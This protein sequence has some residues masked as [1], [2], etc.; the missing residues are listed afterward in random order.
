[1]GALGCGAA[2]RTGA[3]AR[4]QGDRR[5]V[6]GGGD[7][8]PEDVAAVA[9]PVLRHRV[10]INFQ[11]EADGVDPDAIVSRLLSSVRP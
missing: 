2:R 3:P 5:D 1:M 10:L 9:L 8:A 4:S 7:D 6:L 11:A